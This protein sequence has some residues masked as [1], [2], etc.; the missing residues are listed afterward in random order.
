MP[1]ETKRKGPNKGEEV[2]ERESTRTLEVVRENALNAV[3]KPVLEWKLVDGGADGGVGDRGAVVLLWGGAARGYDEVD[4]HVQVPQ[5]LV[6]QL[7]REQ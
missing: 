3:A 2:P 6:A 4:A 7:S 5:E 1:H